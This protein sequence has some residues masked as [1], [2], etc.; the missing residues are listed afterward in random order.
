MPA[1]LHHIV[2]EV[3]KNSMRAVIEHHG[4]NR[5]AEEYPEIK[6]VIVDR[7]NNED[8]CIKVMDEGGGIPR[9]QLQS[10][11]SYMY[12]TAV[13]DAN[14]IFDSIDSGE[15]RDFGGTVPIPLAGM[16]YGL[17]ISRVFARYLGGDIELVSMEGYGTDAY[18]HMRAL[19]DSPEKL[20]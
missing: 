15:A 17:P 5:P 19:G 2:Y 7:E 9:A 11:W 6:V 1:H 16:G 18:I 12:T 10:V 3:L 8:V 14:E 20:P 13:E 4:L